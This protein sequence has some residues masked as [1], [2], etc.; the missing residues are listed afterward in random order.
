M[1]ALCCVA[2]LTGCGGG[3]ED[4]SDGTFTIT[5]SPGGSGVF[6]AWFMP[7]ITQNWRLAAASFRDNSARFQLQSKTV[8]TQKFFSNPLHSSRV[9]YAHAVGLT[10]SGRVISVVDDGFRTAHEAFA[11][12]SNSI[13]GSPAI[14]DHGTMVASVA[15]GNSSSMVGVAPGA[16]L[17]FGSFA[18]YATLT[19]AA[20]DARQRGAVAQNNSWGFAAS[21]INQTSYDN[22]FGNPSG[23]AWLTAL[24]DYAAQ[25]VVV[26]AISNTA[27]ASM[28]GLMDAL[29]VLEPTLEP[30]WLAVGNAVPVFDDDGVSAV[31]FRASAPCLEAARWCLMADGYWTAATAAT[32]TSYGSGTGSSFAA[33]QVSGALAL[34]AQAFPALTPHQLRV[35]L[36]ASADN[37]FSGFVSAGTVDLLDGPGTFL[38]AFSTEFGHG[39]LDIRAALLPIGQTTLAQ[40][41]GGTIE[42]RDFSFSTGGALGDAVTLSLEGID[43]TVN[44]VLG[45]GFDVAARS[46]ASEATPVSLVEAVTTRSLGK[47][48][49]AARTAPINPLADTFGAHPGK[50]LDLVGPEG[51]IKAAVLVGNGEDYGLAVSQTLTDGDL[52]LDVGIKLARDGGSIMGFSGTGNTGGAGMAALTLALSND[53]GD[54]GFFALS[55]EM[56]LADLGAPKAIADVGIARFN[57]LSLDIGSRN[58]FARDDR[59][60]LGLSMPVAVTSGAASMMVPVALGEGRA[61]VRSVDL[62]LAPAERQMEL[63]VSYQMPM[64]ARSELL[65]EA[66]HAENYG[67]R[68]GMSDSAAVIGM[69]WSF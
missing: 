6:G 53:S 36:L 5:P 17:A 64:G 47:D 16:N 41:D 19:A 14:R 46:F 33:P 18:N 25:G 58:V 37:S 23:Q 52:G 60:T 31:A 40:A 55:G 39:F 24:K 42:T 68:A 26:F 43:L 12:K 15:A 32:T 2:L 34:L 59:L 56:G 48:F 50:T 69:K 44:D 51:R 61:E 7:S 49:K 20:V 28:A 10:G 45:A 63:S 1:A 65:F 62:N 13:T 8:T 21:P 35:R 66:V 54:G 38:H 27:S 67:N 29:P 57:S 4:A 22:I 11:G 9:D 30:G 3:E